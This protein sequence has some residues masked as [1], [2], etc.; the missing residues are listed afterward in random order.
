MTLFGISTQF[1]SIWP[2]DKTLLGT[3]SPD[4]SGPKKDGNKG[5]LR[6]H[7]TPALRQPHH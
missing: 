4:Q 7:Q 3:N 6:N 2:I 5:V 1:S